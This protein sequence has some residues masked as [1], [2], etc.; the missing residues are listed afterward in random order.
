MGAVGVHA[1]APW[2]CVGCL[3]CLFRYV[4]VGVAPRAALQV[5]PRMPLVVFFRHKFQV[6]P[7]EMVCQKKVTKASARSAIAKVAKTSASA[8]YLRF[9]AL[10]AYEGLLQLHLYFP[11]PGLNF[12]AAISRGPLLVLPHLRARLDP[13]WVPP[14]LWV[15]HLP[16]IG[17]RF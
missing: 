13:P 10:G 4:F 15:A 8:R 7:T 1:G 17:S 16:M 5:A 12:D 9:P 14:A 2:C 6:R 3:V 11:F